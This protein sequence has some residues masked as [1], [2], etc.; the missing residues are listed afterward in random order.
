MSFFVRVSALSHQFSL[1]LGDFLRLRRDRPSVFVHAHERVPSLRRLGRRRR[2]RRRRRRVT[3]RH[4]CISRES[5]LYSSFFSRCCFSSSKRVFR[6]E[7]DALSR[8]VVVSIGPLF[9]KLEARRECDN[10]KRRY[11][12]YKI[13]I[14][15]SLGT[16]ASPE[17]F[18]TRRKK[19][20]RRET[21]R[22]VVLSARGRKG[23]RCFACKEVSFPV[24][25]SSVVGYTNWSIERVSGI[26]SRG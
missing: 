17:R 4:Y 1:E 2:R 26:L 18:E 5:C 19:A 23:T 3:Q 9:P 11:E 21:E 6:V 24:E 22:V 25:R 16:T 13:R 7:R 20:K 14:S 10:T 15:F 8:S 12:L